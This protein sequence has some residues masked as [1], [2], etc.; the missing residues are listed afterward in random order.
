MQKYIPGPKNDNLRRRLDLLILFIKKY[1]YS[2]KINA[3]PLNYT[4]FINNLKR[5]WKIERLT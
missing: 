4:Q 3:V 2:C 1:V 5:Q